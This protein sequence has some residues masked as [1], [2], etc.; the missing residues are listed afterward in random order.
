MD[1]DAVVRRAGVFIY[2]D[3]DRPVVEIYFCRPAET[4]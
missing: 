2:A 1:T 3:R 4:L